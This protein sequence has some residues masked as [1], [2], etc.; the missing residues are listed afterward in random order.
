MIR[1]LVAEDSPTVRE[2]LVSIL[3]SDPGITV[4]GQAR[5]GREA[6]EMTARL[7]PDLVT[8]DIHMPLLNG[9]EATKAIMIETPTPIIIVSSRASRE[10]IDLSLNATRAGALMVMPIPD[11]PRSERFDEL[12]TQLVAM[13]KAMAQVRVVRRWG[14]KSHA[15]KPLSSGDAPTAPNALV[16]IAASTGGPAA[17]QRILMDLPRAFPAPILVVQHIAPGFVHG[18]A[19]WLG[20]SCDLRVK[21]AEHGEPL[22]RGTIYIAPD[23]HHLGVRQAGRI[24]LSDLPVIDGF[25]PSANHLFETAGSV[26]GASLVAV[27][28]TGMGRDGVEGLRTVHMLGGCVIAQDRASS[29]VFGMPNEA[30]Q[31]GVVDMVLPVHRI[32]SRL[33]TLM[34]GDLN[35]VSDPCS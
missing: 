2:L 15:R 5:N 26:Y 18:L 6:V 19:R 10:E 11:S 8:M 33:V 16:A 29:V 34:L 9:F 3:E 21:V 13:V 1:V 4:V 35:A 32:A 28:L 25:R 30:V 12:R 22:N 17:L 7:R 23:D 27:I 31:A 14:P 24:E 20:A